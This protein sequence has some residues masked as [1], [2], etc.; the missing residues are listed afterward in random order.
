M[1]ISCGSGVD[2]SVDVVTCTGV[3]ECKLAVIYVSM[4]MFD[5]SVIL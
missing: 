1:E 3:A 5:C 2:N 4:S